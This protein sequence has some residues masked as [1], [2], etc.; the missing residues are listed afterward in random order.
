MWESPIELQFGIN[1]MVSEFIKGQTEQTEKYIVESVQSVGIKI[2]KDELI[3][4]INYD[5][6]QYEKGYEDGYSVEYCDACEG[7]WV[8]NENPKNNGRYLVAVQCGKDKGII[9]GKYI[10]GRWMLFENE[11]LI[12]WQPLPEVPES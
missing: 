5:R 4:A 12:A 9:I 6:N 10:D 7:N 8:Y 3:K 11:M 1:D 2:D